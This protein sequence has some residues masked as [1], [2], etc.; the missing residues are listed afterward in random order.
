MISSHAV[1]KRV[2][3]QNMEGRS[4]C[5]DRVLKWERAVLAAACEV[6]NG[7]GQPVGKLFPRGDHAASG[8]SEQAGRGPAWKVPVTW[9]W[10]GQTDPTGPGAV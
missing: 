5:A 4:S 7:L 6:K 2:T 8:Q 10:T 9:G 1:S 3:Q